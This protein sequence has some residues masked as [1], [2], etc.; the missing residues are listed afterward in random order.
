MKKKKKS[1]NSLKK[2]EK[3]G[4]KTK[5]DNNDTPRTYS[6]HNTDN[7]DKVQTSLTQKYSEYFINTYIS[8]L[9]SFRYSRDLPLTKEYIPFTCFIIYFIVLNGLSY[10]VRKYQDKYSAIGKIASLSKFISVPYNAFMVLNSLITAILGIYGLYI[11]GHEHPHLIL[12]EVDGSDL[13]GILGVACYMYYVS[14]YIEVVDTFLLA[15]RGKP[16]SWLH[17]Y[18]HAG[19]FIVVWLFLDSQMLPLAYM[20]ILNSIIHVLMYLYY[21]LCDLKIRVRWK[22]IMTTAQI[23]QL[24]C[25]AVIDPAWFYVK[26]KYNC[27]GDTKIL[28][29]ATAAD[30][31]LIALF[32]NFYY[33]QYT[34]NKNASKNE[35]PKKE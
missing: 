30:G 32:F 3:K 25:A 26:R 29:I 27:I 5:Q 6:A 20:V 33:Q 13:S 23:V 35:K 19:M 17:T 10:F 16:L 9:E 4:K 28:V 1:G 2:K 22:K 11:R 7:M 8:K 24:C 18:H 31:V 34:K 12:C 15:I 14:K 21:L